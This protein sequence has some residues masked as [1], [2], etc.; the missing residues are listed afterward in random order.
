MWG[1]YLYN[2]ALPVKLGASSICTRDINL[3][4]VI[5]Y[6]FCMGQLSHRNI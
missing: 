4:Y 3:I 2:V 6:I 5:M 1:R